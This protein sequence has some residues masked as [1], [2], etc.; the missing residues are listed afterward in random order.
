MTR[1]FSRAARIVREFPSAESAATAAMVGI[2]ALPMIAGAGL[3][4][5]M[6]RAFI[7]E[8]RLGKAL[9]AAGLAAGRVALEDRMETDA[10]AFFAANYPNGLLGSDISAADVNIAIDA[11][12]EFI[13]LSATTEMPTTFL[14]VFGYNS[15]E[16]GTRSV[17]Q[18]LTRGAEIA[19]VMDNTGSM[20][21]SKITA[22]KA[23]A[24][25]LVNI[26]FGSQDSY[27]HL[28]FSLV[29][30]TSAVNIGNT[31]TDWLDAG[32]HV[33]AP[34]SASDPH[35]YPFEP[36][37]WKGCVE[38]R[39]VTNRDETDDPPTVEPFRS[40]LYPSTYNDPDPYA[41]GNEWWDDVDERQQAENR[42]YGPN[43]GCGPAITPLVNQKGTIINAIRG[44]ANWHRGGTTSNLG[45]VWGWRTLSPR[46]RGL[47]DASARPLDYEDPLMQKV[48]IVLTDGENQF[49]DCVG[50]GE[51]SNTD[52]HY[53]S[54]YTAYGRIEDFI[55]GATGVADG[56]DT[57]D[58]KFAR[59]C[60]TMKQDGIIMY[61]ITFGGSA[62]STRVRNLFRNCASDAGNYF[63]APDNASLSAAFRTI[64][65]ELS[66][67]RIVE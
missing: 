12:D 39:W 18:R 56:R 66:N 57:L 6:T 22:M 48:A 41:I 35:D 7:V 16:V 30:Y 11:N 13:T 19:L 17:I 67:L 1:F 34:D 4:L 58:A 28:W 15:V 61:T 36:S 31:R 3:A 40:F 60:T 24:E 64:G 10:R 27:D 23:A 33:F 25:D 14:R 42:G 52:D 38:A 21:G 59:T 5:D 50:G 8:T 54:D 20:K 37:T 26:V 44:M 2:A 46:W 55:P 9:D 29:P 47:W 49:Y 43:L 62:A 32:D 53:V 63:H 51:C 45:L 65:Q